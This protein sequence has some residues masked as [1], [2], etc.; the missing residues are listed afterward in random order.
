MNF[1]F[2]IHPC[3]IMFVCLQIRL[4]LEGV[5]RSHE[6]NCAQRR[7]GAGTAV[8]G[9]EGDRIAVAGKEEEFCRVCPQGAP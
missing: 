9:E 2:N 1:K 8:K 5:G 7:Q 3:L 6:E 4:Q